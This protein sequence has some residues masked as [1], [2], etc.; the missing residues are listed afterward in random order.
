MAQISGTPGPD[1]L[2]GTG[3]DNTIFRFGGDDMLFGSAGDDFIR[4][5]EGDDISGGGP[6]NDSIFAGPDDDGNDISIGGDGD[7]VIGTS[8][9]DDIAIGDFHR[10]STITIGANTNDGADTLFLGDGD[11][12]GILGGYENATADVSYTAALDG[13]I[14]SFVIGTTGGIACLGDGDDIAYGTDG[15]DVISGVP[16][17]LSEDGHHTQHSTR[18][19]TRSEPT[20]R[21]PA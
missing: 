16:I 12:L 19:S 21:S 9:G 11:D 17:P 15:V 20:R 14:A 5:D 1:N 4:G 2:T 10:G 18:P 3:N 7:D 6:G 13:G 8:V